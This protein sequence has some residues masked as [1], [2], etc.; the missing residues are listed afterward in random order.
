MAQWGHR[1]VLHFLPKY[2]PKSNPIERV[3]W[4]LHEEITRNHRCQTMDQLLDLV[5]GWL[6]N[7]LPFE[8]ERHV[9]QPKRAA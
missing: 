9:Y 1:I 3:W 7:R 5:S 4:H 6:E 2:D 8:V